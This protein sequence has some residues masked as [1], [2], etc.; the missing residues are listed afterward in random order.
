ME[1]YE[2][3][4]ADRSLS[5][6]K[7][8]PIAERRLVPRRRF[9][10]GGAALGLAAG[11]VPFAVRA[12]A[13]KKLK[14]YNWDVYMGLTTLA[15]F[16]AKT[17]IEVDSAIYANN[18]EMLAN[19][20][21][22]NPGY[23]IVVPSDYMVAH[24]AQRN[25]LL[26]IDHARLANIDNIDRVFCDPIFDPGLRF[27]V[28]YTFTTVGITYRKSKVMEAPESWKMLLDS[29]RYSGRIAL[30][31]D[32]RV[33][34]GVALRYLGFSV[35]TTNAQEIA[36]ARDLLIR[37]KPRVQWIAGDADLAG[38]LATDGDADLALTW[39]GTAGLLERKDTDYGYVLPREG[40]I[41]AVDALAIPAGAPHV[42]NAYAFIDHVLGAAVD[43]EICNT[44]H[45]STPNAAARLMLSPEERND[46]S[47]YP[48][49]EILAKCEPVLDLGGARRL[50]DAAWDAVL[51]A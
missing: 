18:E 8:M 28:P 23:D 26:P 24:M 51:A 45:Y 3:I 10:L 31:R 46:P 14:L 37:Q 48:P 44:I 13:E 32:A 6:M 41:V 38:V 12:D 34:L 39:S 11:A 21:N 25:M 9:L 20:M 5:G 36:A 19:L 7:P 29:D 40:G 4:N 42:D 17:G 30:V 1:Q 50:Y 27:C 35:N 16:T 33:V 2:H 22:G 43:A 47:L 15:T 49:T